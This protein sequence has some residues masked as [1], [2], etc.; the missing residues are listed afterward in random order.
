VALLDAME[1]GQIAPK[2]VGESVLAAQ[3]RLGCE[4]GVGQEGLGVGMVQE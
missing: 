3:D 2:K 4:H 1:A